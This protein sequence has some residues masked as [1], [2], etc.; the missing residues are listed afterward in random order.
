MSIV[1]KFGGSS[2]SKNGFDVI[3][4]EINKNKNRKVIIVL[5]A[6]YDTTKF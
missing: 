5:S 2:I 1:L 6:L 3:I 4:R